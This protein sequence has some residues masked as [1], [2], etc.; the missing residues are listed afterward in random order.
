[1]SHKA[2]KSMFILL[3]V[4]IVIQ[5]YVFLQSFVH[6]ENSSLDADV[7]DAIIVETWTDIIIDTGFL[8][9]TWTDIIVDTGIVVVDISWSIGSGEDRIPQYDHVPIGLLL[10][11][12]YSDNRDPNRDREHHDAIE[13][14]VPCTWLT[15]LWWCIP[16]PIGVDEEPVTGTHTD[17]TTGDLFKPIEDLTPIDP[18]I[19]LGGWGGGWWGWLHPDDCPDGDLSPSYYDNM[20]NSPIEIETPSWSGVKIVFNDITPVY[21]NE[22]IPVQCYYNDG[23]FVVTN[24]RDITQSPYKKFIIMA[25][26]DCLIH[27]IAD[28]QRYYHPEQYITQWEVLKMIVRKNKGLSTS[29]NHFARKESYP[30]RWTPYLT[31]AQNKWMIRNLSSDRSDDTMYD[32][33]HYND[34]MTLLNHPN[35]RESTRFVSRG[36]FASLLYK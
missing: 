20:C 13:D 11:S 6:D 8:V 28:T 18:P 32:K 30:Y 12:W 15:L 26:S 21:S 23:Q 25:I 19:D 2:K 24:Y 31:I 33:V 10:W 9:E 34:L 22:P 5:M 14:I 27:G 36:E 1:M 4:V 3:W 29:F 7:S 35:S 17:G 16:P